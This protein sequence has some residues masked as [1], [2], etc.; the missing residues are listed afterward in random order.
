MFLEF[1]VNIIIAGFRRQVT[2]TSSPF[3]PQRPL[4]RLAGRRGPLVS[5][6]FLLYGLPNN[7]G[8][9]RLFWRLLLFEFV[10]KFHNFLLIAAQQRGQFPRLAL[11]L[12]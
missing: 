9:Y 6:K 3:A 8:G 11:S 1:T 5:G 7:S 2:I 4:H 12:G 10:P